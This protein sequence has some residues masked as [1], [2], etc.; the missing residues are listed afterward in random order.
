MVDDEFYDSLDRILSSS[1]SSTSAS[2]DEGD[3]RRH[4]FQPPSSA[5]VAAAYEV[6]ITEP[7]PV[8]ERRR[9]LLQVMGLTG[10]T[11]L[12]R[13]KSPIAVVNSGDVSLSVS[14]K[15]IYRQIDPFS[16]TALFAR[17]RSDGAV[18]PSAVH[19]QLLLAP[20]N[21]GAMDRDGDRWCTIRNLDTGREFAVK[22][23]G[24]D[25]MWRRLRERGSAGS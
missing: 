17:S 9:R 19:R 12:C 15:E 5:A 25:G 21:P 8:E 7:G 1:C 22:E 20:Q 4:R 13:G 6:W 18:D 24:E 14:F 16:S 23:F 11:A 2:D 10:D 3:Y